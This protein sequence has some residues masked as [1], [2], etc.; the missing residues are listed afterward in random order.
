MKM[1]T[2]LVAFTISLAGC[3]PADQPADESSK[4]AA[5]DSVAEEIAPGTVHYFL[6]MY[7]SGSPDD[8]DKVSLTFG[9]SAKAAGV[10]YLTGLSSGGGSIPPMALSMCLFQFASGETPYWAFRSFRK[11]ALAN[12][13]HRNDMMLLAIASYVGPIA[14]ECIEREK[15]KGG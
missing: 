11:W 12:P 9:M 4:A 6:E 7:E 2:L 3:S 14:L 15:K 10:A 8:R 1:L 5:S 13:D